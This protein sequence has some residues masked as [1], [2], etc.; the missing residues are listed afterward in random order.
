MLKVVDKQV[1]LVSKQVVIV[2][3]MTTT[4]ERTLT[5]YSHLFLLTGFSFTNILSTNSTALQ[6]LDISWAISA[7]DSP[8]HIAS[9]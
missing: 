4:K 9:T 7:E 1:I 3:T 5:I 2:E 6:I 8:L